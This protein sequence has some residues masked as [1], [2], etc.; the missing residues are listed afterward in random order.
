MKPV[1]C[2]AGPTASGKSAWAVELAQAVDGEIINADSMQVYEDLKILSARPDSAEMKNIPHHLFGHIPSDR[3]Y[4]TGEWCREAVP[5]ILDCLAR[6]KV[7]VLVGGTGLYF[8]ALTDGFANVPPI[9]DAT[10]RETELLLETGIEN[11][12]KKAL[13]LDPIAT[14]RVL[15][16]DPQRLQRIVNVA[17]ETGRPISE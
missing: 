10:K 15:G 8:K 13:E 5:V 4:S 9:T 2:I 11:L 6:D 17:I 3:Q 12:R 14:A 16:D 1:V 7:P